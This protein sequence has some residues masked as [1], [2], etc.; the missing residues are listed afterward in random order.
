MTTL[1]LDLDVVEAFEPLLNPARYK[2]AKGGRGSGKSWFFA[3]EVVMRMVEDPDCRVVCIREVQRSLRYSAKSLIEAKIRSLG[4][5]EC[6]TILEREIRRVGGSGV[7]IFE[8]MQDHTAD[9]IKSL[10]AFDVAWAEEAQSLS[11]RS[12][13]LLTPTIRK[14]G[15]ELWF[16]WNP[17][18]PTDPVDQLLVAEPPGDAIV[19]HA[20]Y[21]DNPFCPRV[22]HDEA[23]RLRRVDPDAYAHVWLGQYNE[24]TESQVLHGKWIVDEFTPDPATWDGPYHGADFGFAQDPTTLVRC[25]VHDRRLYVEREAYKVGL[26]LDHTPEHWRR[27]VPGAEKYVIRADSARPESISYLAR[28]GFPRI[29]GVEKWKG[30]VEDGVAHLR[31]YEQIVIHPD[32]PHT[33]EEA[34]LYSYKVDKKTGDILPQVVDAHDHMWDAI[35]YGLAPLIRQR[36]RG[37]STI[38]F[39][40]V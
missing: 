7:A 17:A 22:L 30:S 23:A 1:A 15:S 16:S 9:S 39:S 14:D 32:C 37:G 19:V 2:G 13:D 27:H 5:Q 3:E 21:T 8:G 10:E 6:F 36:N 40:I 34:R 31:Q 18:Q 33:A 11:K 28:H 4:V 35:R 25:W 24:R 26:E 20:N 29:E 12:L 38:P